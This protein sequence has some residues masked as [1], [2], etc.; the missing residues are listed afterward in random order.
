MSSESVPK[1]LTNPKDRLLVKTYYLIHG[2]FD[3]DILRAMYEIFVSVWG[4]SLGPRLLYRVRQGEFHRHVDEYVP[5]RVPE[6]Y[7]WEPDLDNGLWVCKN[8]KGETIYSGQTV[9]CRAEIESR[10]R[11]AGRN[12]TQ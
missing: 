7:Y 3:W 1:G 12:R 11:K 6:F 4:E 8:P 9:L 2:T 5:D 10:V